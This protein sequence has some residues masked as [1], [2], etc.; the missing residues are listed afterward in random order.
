M[1]QS[2][3][4]ENITTQEPDLKNPMTSSYLFIC[5]ST[6]ILSICFI[7]SLS[8]LF[9]DLMEKRKY[10]R[11]FRNRVFNSRVLIRRID[12]DENEDENDSDETQ[13]R[14]KE[15]NLE[16]VTIPDD[17]TCAICIEEINKDNKNQKICQLQCGHFFHQ[18]CI[19]PWVNT[20]LEESNS[21][22]CPLCRLELEEIKL[23]YV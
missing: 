12:R 4:V 18:D 10:M 21:I 16:E 15:I 5:I 20:I 23:E 17:T 2:T 8:L 13:C 19:S 11:R 14:V 3:E 9:I 1:N 6:I 7:I 22:T